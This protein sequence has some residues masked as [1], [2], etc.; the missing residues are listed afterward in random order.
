[1][2]ALATFAQYGLAAKQNPENTLALFA[3]LEEHSLKCL[4]GKTLEFDILPALKGED[5]FCKTAMPRRENVPCRIDISI[6]R[7]ATLGTSPFSY[8]KSCSTFRTTL[9]YTA[10]ARAGF[11]SVR[12]VDFHE[13]D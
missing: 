8:S 3:A 6:M 7:R 1:M 4:Q 12:F 10:T 2:A 9:A 13:H 11:G 5:S